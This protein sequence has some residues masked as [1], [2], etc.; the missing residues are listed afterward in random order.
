MRRG[1]RAIESKD[2]QKAILEHCRVCSLA[3]SG[4][5]YPY[6][7]PLNYGFVWNEDQEMPVLY[8]HGAPVGTKIEHMERDN[9]V[10]FCVQNEKE[11][12]ILEPACRSTMIYESV[13]GTGRLS[14]VAAPGEKGEALTRIMQ[15]Y[16]PEGGP[17][18]FAP[19]VAAR[20]TVLCL[21][22]ETLTGKSSHETVKTD[23][24]SGAGGT[25]SAAGPR[26]F[27]GC[28]AG[29]GCREKACIRDGS[30]GS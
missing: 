15:Q 6:V 2:G 1:E 8:F 9:R 10:A 7:I 27:S 12:K 28:M 21:R 17:Y 14:R 19:E 5:E 23:V 26:T 18:E 20:T 24:D 22:V 4:D 13:C 16:D 25:A 3:F 29:A 30:F 11:I